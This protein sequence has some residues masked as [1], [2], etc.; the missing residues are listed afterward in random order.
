MPELMTRSANQAQF[1]GKFML[2]FHKYR[3]T[4]WRLGG[5]WVLLL[6]LSSCMKESNA[7]LL[8]RGKLAQKNG[9]LNAALIL[10]KNALERIP[11][12]AESRY[13]LAVV[14]IASGDAVSAEKEVRMAIRLG[15]PANASMPVLAKA[16]LTQGQPQ[17][18]LDET[19]PL[20]AAGKNI[21]LMGVRADSLLALGKLDDA[22][23]LYEEVLRS[24][25]NNGAALIGLGR[26]AVLV[27]DIDA[28]HRYAT[29]AHAA[30]PRDTDAL[31]FRGDLLRAQNQ[32]AQAIAMYD[33][34][35]AIN[36]AHRT[37]HVEK[38]YLAI[39]IGKFAM[40]Q[41]EL[42][43]AGKTT[44]GS[45]LVVY[46]QALLDFSQGKPGAARDSI[47]RVLR[48]AP[49]HM[50]SVLLA[51]AISLHLGSLHQAEHHLRGYLVKHPDN[52]YAR[53]LLTN[54]LLRLGQTPGALT[55]LAPALD[56]PH[57]DVQLLALAGQSYMQARDFNKASE[58]FE[59]ASTL[60]PKAA[61]LRTSLAMSKLGKG[62]LTQAVSDL[63]LAVRLDGNSHEAGMALVRTE[64]G[65]QHVDKALAAV[66]A[67]EK[68]QPDNAVVLDLKGT[69]W[70]AK[71]DVDLARASFNR[72]LVLQP[73]YFPAAA[74]LAQLELRANNP[75]GA[76]QYLQTFLDKNTT[77]VE[78]MTA[79]AS[80]AAADNHMA[81][82]TQWLERA[83]TAAP[84]EVGPAVNLLAQY[85]RAGQVQKGRDLALQLQV[86]YPENPDLLDLLGKSQLANGEL[87]SA[88]ET[89]KKL[90]VALPRS[91]HV[92]M[93][94][95]ALQLVAKRPKDAEAYLKVALAM[96]P[97]FPAAQLAMAELHVQRR[98]YELAQLIASSMQRHHPKASAGFQLEG[99][100]HMAHDKPTLALPAYE[101]ALAMSKTGELTIK[102]VSALRAAGRKEEG[103]KRLALWMQANA[104]D[105][106]A[107]LYQAET[108]LADLQ[109][110]QAARRLEATLKQHPK[111]VIALNNLALA[112]QQSRDARAQ[113]VAEL[114]YTLAPDH[115]VVMDTLGWILV[116]QGD[117]ARAVAI[118][119]QASNKAP[120]ARDIRYHLAMGLYKAG[121]KMAARKE[122]E[123]LVSGNMQFAQ[124]DDVRALL[125][126]VQ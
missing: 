25:A 116:E 101:Q 122:L 28:G 80:I 26:A 7:D 51:G 114:A 107:Q 88:V 104:D 10:Y 70:L 86:S 68:A 73:S 62:E 63:E 119:Q 74:N 20:A 102:A 47:A 124:A 14:H 109:Y 13:L 78:A 90:A 72:A 67:L 87:Q 42:D 54:T 77:S 96:Q 85:F 118:L 16:L 24:E 52:L 12:H 64:L 113:Q 58:Y 41:Q 65:L 40:A 23:Q 37:V 31:M 126:K 49:E 106:R 92:Q 115:P 103:A 18:A 36:P 1:K 8:A 39:A 108:L 17:K 76:R 112:Y 75:Q 11:D 123:L 57:Q 117:V 35:L 4:A 38:S 84:K 79:M 6:M 105:L 33:Q 19:A 121:Q 111:H 44:P 22:K 100:I 61:K 97:D 83:R 46:T 99:D 48:V 45:V 2:R 50:P 5:A 66:L 3:S 95:A 71:R 120:Q 29:L 81:G 21:A 15:Y 93:Q 32:T 59:K 82:A 91:A 53:K 94:V 27:G 30:A 56:T 125:S 98:Q 89:Y 9:D 55:V 69:V 110:Q 43:A 60:D 34:V